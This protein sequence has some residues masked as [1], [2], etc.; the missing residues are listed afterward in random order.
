MIIEDII[1]LICLFIGIIS[2]IYGA[3]FNNIYGILFGLCT[4]IEFS[5][6][7]IIFSDILKWK[8]KNNL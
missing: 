3:V 2:F 4:I 1:C 5:L 8:N 6:I 7:L